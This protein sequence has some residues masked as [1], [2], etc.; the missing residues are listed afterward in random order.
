MLTVKIPEPEAG[1][2]RAYVAHLG[3]KGEKTSAK[4]V[5]LAALHERY[6]AEGDVAGRV[7]RAHGW[8]AG[9]RGPCERTSLALRYLNLAERAAGLALITS[10][11]PPAGEYSAGVSI[12]GEEGRAKYVG[13]LEGAEQ[14][15]REREGGRDSWDADLAA[16][17]ELITRRQRLALAEGGGE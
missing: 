1:Y 8:R 7:L 13:D 14:W 3:A 10:P 17:E 4:A 11:D 9:K 2:L 16:L 6:R 12:I 15:L 5:V